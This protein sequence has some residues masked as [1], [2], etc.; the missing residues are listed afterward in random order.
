MTGHQLSLETMRELLQDAKEAGISLVRLYGG[1]PLLHPDLAAIV[2]CATELELNVYITTNGILL[3]Q[4]IDEL[5]AAGL[6]NITIG[7][8]GT[9][10]E[11][12]KYVQVPDR[13]R[14]LEEGLETVRA[15]YGNA[16]SIQMNFLIMRPSCNVDAVQAAWQFAKRYDMSFR[17]DLIHYSLPYFMEG[18]D[19]KLQFTEEDRPAMEEVVR[20]LAAHKQ[21]DP[22]RF[23]ES[24]MSIQS[25]P[26]WL[27]KGP[28]MRVPC[29]AYHLIWVGADGTVQL[30]YVTFKL[31]NLHEHRL[32]DLLF[33]RA[34]REAARNAFLLRCP[35]CHCERDS[36]IQKHSASRKIYG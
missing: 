35:N 3:K 31:G 10:A 27:L 14:Y 34:H 12:E 19:N 9:G 16:I 21:E 13:F 2:R 4:K 17:T 11:Y 15:R 5:Y 24:M 29:D 7:F 25:I 23:T 30:C 1:E 22:A 36:R 32:R 28:S 20:A 18:L 8:Y 33:T 6:R 26:D